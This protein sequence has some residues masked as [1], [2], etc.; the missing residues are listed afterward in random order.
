MTWFLIALIAPVLWAI[1]DFTDKYLISR[2]F[3]SRGIGALTIFS[4]LI[5]LFLLPIIFFINPNIVNLKFSLIIILILNGI[6]Y[7][8]AGLPYFYAL[9]DSEVTIIAPLYQLI[10]FFSYI[11]GLI[12]FDERLTITQICA[13]LLIILGAILISSN[14]HCKKKAKQ[15]KVFWLMV[16]S[17]FLFSLNF[18]VF[19]YVAIQENFWTTSFWEYVG[20]S[21]FAIFLLL[22][23]K[24][25]RQQFFHVFKKNRF[26]VLRINVVN[27]IVN[28]AGKIII[29]YASLLAPL[30]LVWVVNGVQ[31]FFVLAMGVL[32]AIFFPKLT[33]ESLD[34]KYIFQKVIA[35]VIM[36][37]GMY[38]LNR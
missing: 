4:A 29:N 14:N 5:G 16:L 27:E 23:I 31:P 7:V 38:L 18:L 12:V 10:P 19:K 37:L 3:K 1:T 21:I 11:L 15:K 22:F 26:S 34:K 8:V 9:K 28:I 36:F 13:S 17:A 6:L 2:Y 30:A 20:F 25:Y 33:D 32:L 24:S 35:I